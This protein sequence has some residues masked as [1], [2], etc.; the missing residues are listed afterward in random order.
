MILGVIGM[1]FQ[2]S[3]NFYKA[4]PSTATRNNFRPLNLTQPELGSCA[5]I[6]GVLEANNKSEK[7]PL[8]K[9]IIEEKAWVAMIGVD[10]VWDLM[11]KIA[12][13]ATLPSSTL[14]CKQP[15]AFSLEKTIRDQHVM[16]HQKSACEQPDLLKAEDLAGDVDKKVWDL[17]RCVKQG[18]KEFGNGFT[19]FW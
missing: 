15:S 5:R 13:T 10:S 9:A 16:T 7:K 2:A 3:Q 14:R 6:A 18:V 1:P 11:P 8:M 12:I 4:A 19:W 17:A